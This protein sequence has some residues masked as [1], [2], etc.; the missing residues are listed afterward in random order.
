MPAVPS[1]TVL[2]RSILLGWDVLSPHNSTSPQ[3]TLN[4]WCIPSSQKT[5]PSSVLGCGDTPGCSW[6]PQGAG[7]HPTLLGEAVPAALPGRAPQR[8]IRNNLHLPAGAGGAIRHAAGADGNVTVLCLFPLRCLF[9]VFFLPFP[10]GSPRGIGTQRWLQ[11]PWV[12]SPARWREAMLAGSCSQGRRAVP[13][14]SQ[15]PFPALFPTMDHRHEAGRML[16]AVSALGEAGCQRHGL[17]TG[18]GS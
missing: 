4:P 17:S 9:L 6:P 18:S 11:H 13:A 8:S 7:T 16:T 10:Y 5:T 14:G 1:R 3:E 12:P 2:P 15:S